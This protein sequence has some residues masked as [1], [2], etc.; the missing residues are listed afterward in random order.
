VSDR[1]DLVEL[2]GD[3]PSKEGFVRVIYDTAPLHDVRL[4]F[5]EAFGGPADVVWVW[6]VVCVEDA[7]VV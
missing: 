4:F 6:A 5:E 1:V 3:H 7:G 2:D